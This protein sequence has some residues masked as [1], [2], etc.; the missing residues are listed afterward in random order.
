MKTIEDID[1]YTFEHILKYLKLIDL[2]HAASSNPH[3][4]EAC[5]YEFSRRCAKKEIILR[6]IE[7]TPEYCEEANDKVIVYS[8]KYIL[9]LLR[10]FG[11]L[12][13]NVT[14]E[15]FNR[16]VEAAY[17][18]KYLCLYCSSSLKKIC[19]RNL[20]FDIVRFLN[21][22][23]INVEEIVFVSC[24][25]SENFRHLT[26][27]FPNV[28]IMDFYGWNTFCACSEFCQDLVKGC[29]FFQLIKKFGIIVRSDD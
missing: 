5:R 23:L 4:R 22:S 13:K 17:L 16:S 11:D 26:L 8:L 19:F 3:L 20:F 28:K 1:V 2:I 7:I 15:F 18:I 9:Q 12:I 21:R 25:L 14:I 24:I 29:E 10:M 27:F 6:L